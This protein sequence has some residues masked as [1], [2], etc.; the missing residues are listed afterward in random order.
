MRGGAS[1][2]RPKTWPFVSS[3]APTTNEVPTRLRLFKHT[4]ARARWAH[5]RDGAR[6]RRRR[7]RASLDRAVQRTSSH[8]GQGGVHGG[9]SRRGGRRAGERIFSRRPARNRPVPWAHR[10]AREI[11]SRRRPPLAIVTPTRSRGRDPR[12]RSS[13]PRPLLARYSR[14][15]LPHPRPR[16]SARPLTSS[17]HPVQNPRAVAI[18]Q[19]QPPPGGPTPRPPSA[20][21]SATAPAWTSQTLTKMPP[22]APPTPERRATP[23]AARPPRFPPPPP[24]PR[25]A[26]PASRWCAPPPS[27]KYELLADVF[28]A[29][30]QVGPLLRKRQQACT[31]DVVCSSVETMTRRRCTVDVLRSIE[32]IKPGTVSFSVR[33][34]ARG[35][36]N[37]RDGPISPRRVRADVAVPAGTAQGTAGMTPGTV[38][39]RP[40]RRERRWRLF[41]A[42]MVRLVGA[43]HDAF[44]A[45]LGDDAANDEEGPVIVNGQVVEWHPKFDLESCPD[46]PSGPAPRGADSSVVANARLSAASKA[47]VAEHPRVGN[48]SAMPANWGRANLDSGDVKARAIAARGV[49]DE[50]AAAA[51][52]A[53][54]DAGGSFP[55]RRRRGD[56]AKSGGGSRRGSRDDRGTS[57]SSAVRYPSVALRH[58]AAAVRDVQEEGV[59]L[60]GSAPT[61]PPHHHA[62]EFEPDGG[63]G[64]VAVTRGVIARVVRADAGVGDG[65]R[66]GA[67]ETQD[68]G[69]GG[70]ALRF[71]RNSSR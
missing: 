18:H 22:R 16:A 37:A 5:C 59:D 46:P 6:D 24:R 26:L 69:R 63:G 38:G 65:Q 3:R 32:T 58:D 2:S 41:R 17:Q 44:L 43:H 48:G 8:D 29:L 13:V 50:E 55:S 20:D 30:Q 7:P 12:R 19:H 45:R 49:T 23:N 70:D 27:Q 10:R 28:I 57:A 68:G 56:E 15:E 51:A 36:G 9:I 42:A 66:G 47:D 33:G 71:G 39:D 61:R 60:R 53:L 52:A 64:G 62:A 67:L 11:S 35:S 21:A 25:P 1:E 34:D 14:R 31:A 4:S 40:R 54:G